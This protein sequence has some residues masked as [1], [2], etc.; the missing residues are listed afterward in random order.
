[1]SYKMSPY[2]CTCRMSSVNSASIDPPEPILDPWCP[3]HGKDPDD[4][5][6]KRR[7]NAAWRKQCGWED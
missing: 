2:S 1:M 7:D 4:E 6:E 5:R 3:L